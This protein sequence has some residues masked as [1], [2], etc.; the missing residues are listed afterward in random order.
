M[1]EASRNTETRSQEIDR[2]FMEDAQRGVA[3]A[4]NF[5]GDACG[6]CGNFTMTRTGT[7]MT[8]VSCGTTSGCS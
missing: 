7:C 1:T 6:E 3:R 8:C 5:T 4:M 2:R